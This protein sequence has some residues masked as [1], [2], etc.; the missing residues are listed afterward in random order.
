MDG[1]NA[2]VAATFG[3][4][5]GNSI[6]IHS[7]TKSPHSIGLLYSAFTYYCGFN[8]NADEYKLMGLAPYGEPV[9]VDLILEKLIKLRTNGAFHV[10]LDYFNCYSK[11]KKANKT[12]GQIN[13]SA[14]YIEKRTALFGTS[15]REI[16]RNY[17]VMISTLNMAEE[18]DRFSAS[19]LKSGF[20][21]F[22]KTGTTII[23]AIMLYKRG[24]ELSEQSN[25][26]RVIREASKK[27]GN[28]LDNLRSCFIEF[29][30]NC[31]HIHTE[32][33]LKLANGD[34]SNPDK[35]GSQT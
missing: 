1:L 20:E 9:Y 16:I 12:G 27:L 21:E 33:A 32:L 15:T 24:A 23:D 26:T 18:K 19:N 29:Q 11:L 13:R 17:E 6:K 34:S 3:S 7:L 28:S 2:H 30:G 31:Q 4:G 22:D 10:N 35:E 25:L 14:I 8:P 5:I